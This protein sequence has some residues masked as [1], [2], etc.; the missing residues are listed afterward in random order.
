MVEIF[1]YIACLHSLKFHSFLV[2]GNKSPQNRQYFNNK[3]KLQKW[4][5]SAFLL[6]AIFKSLLYTYTICLPAELKETL[7]IVTNTG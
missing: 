4:Y 3:T 6:S 7:G 2:L 5:Q 1:Y